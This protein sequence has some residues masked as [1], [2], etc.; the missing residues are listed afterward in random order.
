[1]NS[2]LLE[3][4]YQTV[5]LIFFVCVVC[6]I[7]SPSIIA[8]VNIT[9]IRPNNIFPISQHVVLVQVWP[10]NLFNLLDF[11]KVRYLACN[12]LM[13]CFFGQYVPDGCIT[14]LGLKVVCNLLEGLL[15]AFFGCISDLL[16]QT[17]CDNLQTARAWAVFGGTCLLILFSNVS[18]SGFLEVCHLGCFT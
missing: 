14:D 5:L 7:H 13:I 11:C 2:R 10:M 1:M 16:F 18:G 8:E 15:L 6:N 12:V 4:W 17:I 9:L 3:H